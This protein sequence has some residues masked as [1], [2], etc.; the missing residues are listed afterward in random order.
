LIT[1]DARAGW[2]RGP[3]SSPLAFEGVMENQVESRNRRRVARAGTVIDQVKSTATS[4]APVR[5]GR[6]S[7]KVFVADDSS[8]IRE[9]IIGMLSVVRG[10]EI[11]GQA[12]DAPEA[13]DSIKRLKPDVVI[14]DIQMPGGS[15]IDVLQQIKRAEPAPIVMMLTNHP[16]SPYREKCLKAGAE[17]FFDKSTEFEKV[18][19]A[20]GELIQRLDAPAIAAPKGLSP[21]EESDA[22]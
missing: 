19:E 16:Y 20:L 21:R 15:G 9:R 14:L 12:Q 7:M 8:I 5:T 10:I 11:T 13:T 4:D 18:R 6:G 22:S 2:Q 17:F 1:T 3:E